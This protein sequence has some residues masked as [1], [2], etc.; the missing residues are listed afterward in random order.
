M[1][2]DVLFE[3]ADGVGK[4]TLNR[5]QQLNALT[6]DMLSKRAGKS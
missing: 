5:P 4:A 3:V 2:T 6:L 1:F